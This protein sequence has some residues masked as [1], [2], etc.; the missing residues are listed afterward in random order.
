MKK[1]SYIFLIF[2]CF[3]SFQLAS[4]SKIQ[5]AV[6]FSL[7]PSAKT[8]GVNDTFDVLL[9]LDT[10]GQT[11]SGGSAVLTYDPVRLLVVDADTGKTGTQ[12]FSGSIF[13]IPI[14]NMVD[15]A[16]GKI[17]LDYGKSAGSFSASGNFGKITFKAI[18]SGSTV[19][20]YLLGSAQSATASAVYASGANVL[21]AVNSGSYSISSSVSSVSATMT[22]GEI[23]PQAGVVENTIAIFLA[24]VTFVAGGLFFFK[25]FRA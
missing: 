12:I 15:T 19:V 18:S 11:I 5:A 23:L 22:S 4:P 24:G 10:G 13:T 1:T 7:S 16:A 6:A 3:L 21:A 17:I 9:V 14:T 20:S 25:K 2:F 8:I